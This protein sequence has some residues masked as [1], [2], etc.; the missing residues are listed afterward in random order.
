MDK[1][2][3]NNPNTDR[4][5]LIQENFGNIVY[6]ETYDIE[7]YKKAL[8]LFYSS[9][10]FLNMSQARQIE[11]ASI[12][13]DLK[14][15][16]KQQQVPG[17]F[18]IPNRFYMDAWKTG[19][20][21]FSNTRKF[22][23]KKGDWEFRQAID[24]FRG[25]LSY[26]QKSD[27]RFDEK[28]GNLLWDIYQREDLS[29]G[30]HGTEL[31][32]NFDISQDNCDF[33]KH[34]IMVGR[35]YVSGD[36]RRTVNFQ[37]LPGKQ[38]SFGNVSFLKLLNYQYR[39]RN[40]TYKIEGPKANYSVIV[41]RPSSMKDT[42]FDPDCPQEYSI[43][44]DSTTIETNEGRYLS[45]HLVKG[46]YVLGIIKNNEFFVRNPRCD[47]EAISALNGPIKLRNEEIERKRLSERL[48]EET[49]YVSA[50]QKK[51]V[52]DRLKGLIRGPKEQGLDKGR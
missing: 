40:Q 24:Y 26:V 50:R 18:K 31:L 2:E 39:S 20:N 23:G 17:K 41:V 3:F 9:E 16:M 8:Q 27:N 46:S 15:S 38:W 32:D 14:K 19:I 34:G 28:M 47:L 35:E 52:F 42:S 21:E 4:M 1:K 29:I 44:T 51:T 11:I 22:E 12:F 45:G 10:K 36:A 25:N 30:I 7:L 48:A 13:K 6:D 43:V 49:K 37:D 5:S 33:F